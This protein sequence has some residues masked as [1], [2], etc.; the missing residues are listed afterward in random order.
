M[1]E[2]QERLD[3]LDVE[4][5]EM[6]RRQAHLE[7]ESQAMRKLI[8]TMSLQTV[9]ELSKEALKK[10]HRVAS[11]DDEKQKLILIMEQTLEP[12][13]A[14]RIAAWNSLRTMHCECPDCPTRE[15]KKNYPRACQPKKCILGDAELILRDLTTLT[16]VIG[17]GPLSHEYFEE[18]MEHALKE[19]CGR[20]EL[21]KVEKS[22][23]K[24]S[25]KKAIELGRSRT[26]FKTFCTSEKMHGP[27]LSD[28][29]L[30]QVYRVYSAVANENPNYVSKT[31][32][33]K[34]RKPKNK[35]ET[36]GAE[37][38]QMQH[39]EE[40]E[41]MLHQVEHY[42]ANTELYKDT[43]HFDDPQHYLDQDP[44]LPTFMPAFPC[45]SCKSENI[46]GAMTEYGF[47]CSMC[48]YMYS[49]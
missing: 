43:Q 46:N 39:Q 13:A 49:F 24:L 33:G 36:E 1:Q 14:S 4:V 38:D 8:M 22:M 32:A 37:D 16:V 9:A 31:K 2:F 12:S 3:A 23:F 48:Y 15:S 45:I 21:D 28:D 20:D 29:Q 44:C 18:L 7:E 17:R 5:A 40:A 10:A 27:D 35:E 30:D 47:K 11:T 41:Q 19:G 34:K 42:L 25:L 6:K 26:R